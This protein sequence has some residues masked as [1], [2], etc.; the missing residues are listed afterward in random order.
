[1]EATLSSGSDGFGPSSSTILSYLSTVSC[2]TTQSSSGGSPVSAPS[3]SSPT[4]PRASPVS[5]P[6]PVSTTTTFDGCQ[7]TAEVDAPKCISVGNISP[8]FSCYSL[9]EILPP[10]CAKKNARWILADCDG[11][12]F[13]R[14]RTKSFIAASTTNCNKSCIRSTR[15]RVC[16]RASSNIDQHTL[17]LVAVDRDSGRRI[18]G[19]PTLE[20]IIPVKKKN[21]NGSCRPANLKCLVE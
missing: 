15:N 6:S 10:I 11:I 3:P 1:M 7:L 21:T 20:R 17:T 5:A 14:R 16:L 12:A 4:S 13:S 2:D 18:D 19:S 9:S 8:G